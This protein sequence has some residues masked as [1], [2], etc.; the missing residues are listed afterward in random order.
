MTGSLLIPILIALIVVGAFLVILTDDGDADR[1]ILWLITIAVLP[2]VGLLLYLMFGI[3]YRHRKY[4]LKKHERYAHWYMQRQ[5]DR[6]DKLLGGD[7]SQVDAAYHP[8]TK[9]LA[10]RIRPGVTGGNDIEIITHG[11]RKLEALLN[12]IAQA[13]E[14]IH[15]QYYLFGDDVS[16]QAVKEVLMKKAKG[17]T[18]MAAAQKLGA[19]IDTVN[20]VTFDAPVFIPQTG[21]SEPA[22]SGAV[23]ATAKGKVSAPVKGNQGLYVFQVLDKKSRDVKFNEKDAERAVKQKNLQNISQYMRDLVEKANVVDNR[24]LFF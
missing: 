21:A 1:K 12:D 24:Y 13:R 18:D 22:L 6:I 19:K 7:T 9:L 8:F 10:G 15:F 16:G 2:V 14:Y 17:A 23:F 4:F 20:Q 3:N 5:G 11:P